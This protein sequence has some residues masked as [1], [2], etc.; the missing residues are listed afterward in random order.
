MK[1][2]LIHEQDQRTFAVVFDKGDEVTAGRLDFARK[3]HLAA[4]SFTAIGA[5]SDVTLGYFERERKNYKKIPLKEQV[6]PLALIGNIALSDGEPKAPAHV[7]VGCADGTAH[8][9]QLVAA[10]VWPTLEVIVIESPQRLR[11]KT[12]QATGLGLIDL[13]EV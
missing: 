1:A 12:D 8:G 7:V 9:G 6:E 2:K 5:L 13:A 10:H 4:A 3:N 11:R